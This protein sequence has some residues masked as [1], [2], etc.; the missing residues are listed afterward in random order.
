MSIKTI[1][2]GNVKRYDGTVEKFNHRFSSETTEAEGIAG[3]ITIATASRD[4]SIFPVGLIKAT[5]VFLETDNKIRISCY[6]DVNASI[7]VFAGGI[8]AVNGSISDIR[9]YNT[10]ATNTCNIDYLITG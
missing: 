9:L 10:S 8:F 1:F 5:S 3:R 7:D 4:L 2:S 6:G